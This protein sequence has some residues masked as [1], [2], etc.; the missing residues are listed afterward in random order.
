[1]RVVV[2]AGYGG[3][4][5]LQLME[6]PEPVVK[7]DEIKIRIYAATVTAGDCE[8][9]RFD[10][11]A[12]LW[13]PMR[14]FL[15]VFK[16]RKGVLGQEVAGE[17]VAIGDKVT[18]FQPGDKVYAATLFRF[19]AYAEYICLPQTYP[20]SLIPDGLSFAQAATIPT[21][22]VNALHFLR[23]AQV[24]SGDRILINGAGGSIGTYAVQ[25]AKILGATVDCSDSANKLEG[26]KRLGAE[27]VFDYQSEDVFT[28]RASY[29]AVIDVVGKKAT[30]DALS[31]LKVGGCYVLGAPSLGGMISASRRNKKGPGKILFEFADY[32]PELLTA[33]NRWLSE[34]KLTPLIDREY[35][36]AEVRAAHAYVDSGQKFGN[37]VINVIP[38]DQ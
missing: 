26:L 12:F 29:D 37:L 13:L 16:P 21:G 27:R 31:A 25:L 9:R 3:P 24:K 10:F 2:C 34:G 17:I 32:K 23:L 5:R 7:D 8:A 18:R 35:P 11:P 28:Q 6:R 14:L 30:D 1:M 20:V 15:G 33:L 38:A 36:L 4:D 22:G 19:G